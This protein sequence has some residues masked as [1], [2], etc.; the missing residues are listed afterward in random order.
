[1]LSNG[2]R[3][4]LRHMAPLIDL[5]LLRAV[6]ALLASHATTE[7]LLIVMDAITEGSKEMGY[8][9]HEDHAAQLAWIAGALGLEADQ[10]RGH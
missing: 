4:P 7:T 5:T 10:R 9:G 3:E 8:A 6:D 2:R 1:M